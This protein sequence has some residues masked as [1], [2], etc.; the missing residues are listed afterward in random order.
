M[1]RPLQVKYFALPLG[2]LFLALLLFF[3]AKTPENKNI[4]TEL[5]EEQANIELALA[6][7][8]GGKTPMKGILMLRS[9]KD[10][11]PESPEV[12]WYLGQFSMETRQYDKA[13]EYLLRFVSIAEEKDS[14]RQNAGKILLSDACAAQGKHEQAIDL[15]IEV[16]KNTSDS[17]FVRAVI[18]RISNYLK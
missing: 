18:E 7:I 2:S 10:K 6:Y 3:S 14:V 16:K 13:E 4:G 12:F 1:K 11:Y 15:L 8:G 9:L 5:T 17:V